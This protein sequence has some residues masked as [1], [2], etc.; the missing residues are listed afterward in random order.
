MQRVFLFD[1][2]GVLCDDPHLIWLRNRGLID[3]V[4]AL[5]EQYYQYSDIGT[6]SPKELYAHLAEVSGMTAVEVESSVRGNLKID[7]QVE[8]MIRSLKASYKVGL[9]SN[10][11]QGFVED[12]LKEHS[13]TDLFDTT[14]ISS[15]VGFR[16]P[17]KEMFLYALRKLGAEPSETI[18]IDDNESYVRVAVEMEFS[19][20]V[21]SSA[22]Q[23][24]EDLHSIGVQ[25]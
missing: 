23:L 18:F 11:Q 20:F 13:L 24:M 5:I 16:K 6:M 10:A 8:Q 21:F 19:A 14:V 9:C 7:P 12:I 3:Q 17:N 22:R 25:I 2:F 4:P 1:F 15:Q